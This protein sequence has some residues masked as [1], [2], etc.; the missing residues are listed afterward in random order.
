MSLSQA[1]ERGSRRVRRVPDEI[2]RG[3]GS[4]PRELS[5]S[6]K[7]W[8]KIPWHLARASFTAASSPLRLERP[9][10]AALMGTAG[11]SQ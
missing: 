8:R 4:A 11:G 5:K 1:P 2:I 7:P 9:A 3:A 10:R 6:S